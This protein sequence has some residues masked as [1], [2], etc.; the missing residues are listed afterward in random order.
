MPDS[1]KK[2]VVVR[3]STKKRDVV[4]LSTTELREV[5]RWILTGSFSKEFYSDVNKI[6]LSRV[7]LIKRA[8]FSDVEEINRIMLNNSQ[9]VTKPETLLLTLVFLSMGSFHAKKTFKTS[10]EK[11]VK[12]PNDLYLFLSLAKKYRGMGSIIHLAI[13]KWLS[14]H[15]VHALERAFVEEGARYG[16]SG[17]D[18]IRIIKPKPR[19]KEESLIFKWLVTGKISSNDST[20]YSRRLPLISLYEEF[21][22]NTF[23][24]P[25]VD[26]MEHNNFPPTAIPGNVFRSKDILLKV[27]DSK[28]DE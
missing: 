4:S 9:I 11:I 3:R 13:K 19:N 17:Q 20:E 24:E 28:T 18:I 26:L 6:D 5:K 7:H 10:F 15:D 8:A 14:S 1:K 16:W 12:T 2:V 23:N 21:R 22:N 25:I 27:L